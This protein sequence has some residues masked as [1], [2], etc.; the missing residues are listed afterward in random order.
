MPTSGQ[1]VFDD[2]QMSADIQVPIFPSFSRQFPIL[3][4]VVIGTITNVA[5]DPLEST[6]IPPPTAS[7]A[8]TNA[9]LNILSQ[10]A[11]VIPR[12]VNPN[13]GPSGTGTG[14]PG[15]NVF[16]FERATIR[17]NERVNGFHVARVY[18]LRSSVDYS[19]ATEVNYRMDYIHPCGDGNNTFENLTD[20]EVPLQAG[21]DYAGFIT[22]DCDGTYS[23]NIHFAITNGTLHW[24]ANDG[25]PKFIEIPITDDDV[26]QF[27]EDILLQLYL[28]GPKYPNASSERSLGYV[29][30]CNLTILFSD[31]PAGAVDGA[32]NPEN[33]SDTHPAYN[34]HPGPNAPVYA[35]A[36]QTDGKAIIGGDFTDYNG[37]GVVNNQANIYRLA[38]VNTDGSL[39]QS[40]NTRNGADQ[41][42]NALAIDSS[43]KVVVGG[44]FTSIDR[45]PRN[46]IARVN[47]NGSLDTTFG[48]N[49]P[50]ADGT[51]LVADTGLDL[52][53]EVSLQGE[54]LREWSVLEDD[55]WQRFSRA[56]DYRKV[57]ETKPHKSHPNHV[58]R[59][60]D[61]ITKSRFGIARAH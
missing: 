54:V 59:L 35:I 58:F 42:V 23:D 43:G 10:V 40:F 44:A 27:N 56:I 11:M 3:N 4:R 6:A 57:P 50:G 45:V 39:D 28:P 8:G 13:S 46:R 17:C 18:V 20:W 30:T 48:L 34:L 19:Q 16:N 14:F 15:T 2:F 37:I 49:Q 22:E 52:V 38:R 9:L 7:T 31:Q 33:N 32:Y 55:T 53:V 24:N 60:G 61:E 47:A 12:E 36:T 21:S 41:A 29:Q 51:V 5:L 25:Q 1:L 26:V